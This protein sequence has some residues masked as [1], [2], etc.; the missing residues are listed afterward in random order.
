[1]KPIK[2][3]P[4]VS[5]SIRDIKTLFDEIYNALKEFD[6]KVESSLAYLRMI[7]SREKTFISMKDVV[8]KKANNIKS[9]FEGYDQ[10]VQ[11]V[12]AISVEIN[13]SLKEYE[14]LIKDALQVCDASLSLDE[15]NK[16]AEDTASKLDTITNSLGRAD[17][18]LQELCKRNIEN[19]NSYKRNA[20]R[21][22][23]VLKEAKIDVTVFRNAFEATISEA[24][25]N[26]TKLSLG[27]DVKLTWKD[28]WDDLEKLKKKLFD[29]VKQ[30]L[31]ED[32][33]NVLF[34]VVEAAPSRRWF[35]SS[36]LV[37]TVVSN[38]QKTHKQALDLIESLVDKKLLKKGISLP[39]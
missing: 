3:K 21:F 10:E 29:R 4:L 26:L 15:I 11:T 38:F 6:G 14:K 1:M 2:A 22:L 32:E 31:S 30:I 27:S 7:M 34:L 28:V 17:T 24:N 13:A 19:L 39:I 18:K 33:F 8:L 5:L 9:F 16:A 35:D 23:E 37:E 20:E 25:N 36:E 12:S